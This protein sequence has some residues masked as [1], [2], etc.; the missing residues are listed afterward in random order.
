METELAAK[1]SQG[2]ELRKKLE[3]IRAQ[4]KENEQET[5]HLSR[6][7]ENAAFGSTLP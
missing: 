1:K 3:A 5:R 6:V 7:T 4:V 2:A